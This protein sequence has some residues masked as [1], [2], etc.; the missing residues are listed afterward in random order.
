MKI[1][2]WKKRPG[3]GLHSFKY[4]GQRH[5]TRPGDAV[6][7]PL[8]AFG[9]FSEEYACLGEI[10]EDGL[11]DADPI[12][13]QEEAEE[14][15]NQIPALEIVPVGGG[16]YDVIN[17]DNPDKPLNDKSLRKADAQELAGIF[18]E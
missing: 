11:K 2:R 12:A 8:S 5:F 7:A 18:E 15:A 16:W 6:V 14:E 4:D 17:P 10:T 13:E 3:T 1:Y 9:S